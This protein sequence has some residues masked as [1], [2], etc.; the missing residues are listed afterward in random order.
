MFLV[1]MVY[2]SKISDQFT[3]ADIDLILK[4][5]RDNNHKKHVSGLLCFNRKY[6]LQCLE[7]G[8]QSV[9]E[10]YRKILNDPRHENIIILNYH[11]I[12]HRD[13]EQWSMAYLPEI[14]LT[15]EVNLKY[16]GAPNFD[17]YSM[18]VES[19]YKLMLDIRKNIPTV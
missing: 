19:A 8:R 7:G 10:I 16:S 13:F 4:K 2:C 3:A 14:K 15:D 11:E 12:V 9:N 1:R 6:F 5:A 18:H 17:P